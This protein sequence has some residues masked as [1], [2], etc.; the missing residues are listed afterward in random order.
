MI[1]LNARIVP[2]VQELK[3]TKK[4]TLTGAE[5]RDLIRTLGVK[6]PA[7]ATISVYVPGGGDW[8][9]SD[10]DIN[11]H[12]VT[13]VWKESH[14]AVLDENGVLTVGNNSMGIE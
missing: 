5:I 11:E 12:P 2:R 7:D 13:I 4:I 6:V 8:S 10:L 14:E 9:H 1:S 3:V